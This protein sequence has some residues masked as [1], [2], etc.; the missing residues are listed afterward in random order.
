MQIIKTCF[1]LDILDGLV[2]KLKS[3]FSPFSKNK[4]KYLPLLSYCVSVHF[5]TQSK[6]EFKENKLVRKCVLFWSLC[7]RENFLCN[8]ENVYREY[9]EKAV[10]IS[11][12]LFS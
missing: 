6:N 9:L 3:I 5:H 4:T 10:F 8:I 7:L 11:L 12:Q 2:F 1:Q